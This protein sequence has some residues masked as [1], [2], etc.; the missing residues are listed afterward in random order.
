LPAKILK[1]DAVA[2]WGQLTMLDGHQP[3]FAHPSPAALSRPPSKA[4]LRYLAE[5]NAAA[6][7]I[8]DD[9]GRC[10][11][12][13]KIR[14]HAVAIYWTDA[15]ALSKIVQRARRHAGEH[16]TCEDLVR[17]LHLAASQERVALT[18]HARAIERAEDSVRRLDSYMESFRKSGGLQEFNRQFQQRRLAAGHR[19]ETS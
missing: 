5:A 3:E 4:A 8:T 13:A 19:G 7:C 1:A 2:K 12:R 9:A 15:A 16:P 6:L 11:I 10:R 17:A 14:P 18:P